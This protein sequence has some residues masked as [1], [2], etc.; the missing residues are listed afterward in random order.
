[1]EEKAERRGRTAKSC[2]LGPVMVMTMVEAC[3]PSRR[4]GVESHLGGCARTSPVLKVVNSLPMSA[5]EWEVGMPCTRSC[6]EGR[7]RDRYFPPERFLNTTP[8]SHDDFW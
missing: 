8:K 5:R 3:F 1:V 4:D 2:A 6:A 7:L